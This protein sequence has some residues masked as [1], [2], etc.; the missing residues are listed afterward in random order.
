MQIIEEKSALSLAKNKKLNPNLGNKKTQTSIKASINMEKYFWSIE[1]KTNSILKTIYEC[2][3]EFR[4]KASRKRRQQ[5]Q[6]HKM[7]N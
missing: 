6:K 1:K 3:T 7:L 5:N 2:N 4:T